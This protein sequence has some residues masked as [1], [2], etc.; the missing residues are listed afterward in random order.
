MTIKIRLM[1]MD[2][3]SITRFWSHLVL[4][5]FGC[6]NIHVGI[7]KKIVNSFERDWTSNTRMFLQP[8]MT[9][10]MKSPY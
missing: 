8:R 6:Q 2:V 7:S 5:F 3:K 9:F 10:D 1:M 4:H